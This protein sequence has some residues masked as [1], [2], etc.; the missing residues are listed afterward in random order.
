M[1]DLQKLLAVGVKPHNA[2]LYL[3][4]L[5]DTMPEYGIV[6]DNAQRHFIAQLL[7]ESA[8]FARIIENFNYTP[9]ALLKTFRSRFTALQAAELGRGAYR[10]A[11]QQD[12]ANQAYGLRYGNK[13]K[14]DGWKYRGRGLIMLTFKDNYA[15]MA[16]SLNIDLINQP[17]LLCEPVTSVKA[18]CIYFNGWNKLAV[19]ADSNNIDLIKAQGYPGSKTQDIELLKVEAITKVINGGQNGLLERKSLYLALK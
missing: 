11:R 9:E 19:I 17:E 3:P 8:M 5:Q 14:G 15:R 1:I 16:K 13:E 7:H 12:I 2:N 10:R 18:A 6:T 4:I